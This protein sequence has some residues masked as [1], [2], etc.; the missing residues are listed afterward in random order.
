MKIDYFTAIF[1]AP[2]SKIKMRIAIFGLLIYSIILPTKK[3]IT[4]TES[5]ITYM[6]L[7][8]NF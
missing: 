3:Y 1:K 5:S 4:L 6:S 7:Y 8:L 2:Y